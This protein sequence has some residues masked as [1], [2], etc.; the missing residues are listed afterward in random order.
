MDNEE[1]RLRE[2]RIGR[3]VRKALRQLLRDIETE[4][5]LVI[6]S[7]DSEDSASGET[8][9]DIRVWLFRRRPD[10]GYSVSRADKQR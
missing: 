5:A 9:A 1:G 10:N 8:I 3:A 2:K 7:H 4:P 6:E